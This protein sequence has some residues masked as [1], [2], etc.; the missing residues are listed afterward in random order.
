MTTQDQGQLAVLVCCDDLQEARDWLLLNER[1][2][3]IHDGVYALSFMKGHFECTNVDSS[4]PVSLTVGQLDELKDRALAIC[5]PDWNFAPNWR[6]AIRQAEKFFQIKSVTGRRLIREKNAPAGVTY[7]DTT[8]GLISR[9]ITEWNLSG[10]IH[11]VACLRLPDDLL[12]VSPA[13]SGTMLRCLAMA[14]TLA[15]AVTSFYDQNMTLK[16]SG[17]NVYLPDFIAFQS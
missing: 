7:Q 2:T 8:P 11:G 10:A 12:W 5:T 1:W 17:K 14:A 13:A 6:D 4:L 16:Y 9:H 15:E 3:T